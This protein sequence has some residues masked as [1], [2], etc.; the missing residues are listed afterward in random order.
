[1]AYWVVCIAPDTLKSRLQASPPGK[2]SGVS[3]VFMDM[4]REKIF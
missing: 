3:Q 4:V 1:M 2:Y